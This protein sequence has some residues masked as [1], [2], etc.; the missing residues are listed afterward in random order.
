[1]VSAGAGAGPPQWRGVV[2]PGPRV[3][4]FGGDGGSEADRFLSRVRVRCRAYGQRVR[5]GGQSDRSN[6]RLP[7]PACIESGSAPMFA[8]LLRVRP[9]P[10]RRP[11]SSRTGIPARPGVVFRR[12]RRNGSPSVRER[13]AGEGV[14]GACRSRELGPG[15]IRFI[16]APVLG[17]PRYATTRD[18]AGTTAA[19]YRQHGRRRVGAFARGRSF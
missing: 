13:R 8:Y 6:P 18:A 19:V 16:V 17:R 14:G 12:A 4:W 1:M 3:F 7:R 5:G 2:R 15:G 10:A 11:G 9:D